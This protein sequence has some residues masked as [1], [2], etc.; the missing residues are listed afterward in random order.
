MTFE[1]G[2]LVRPARAHLDD[3]GDPDP[4]GV[5]VGWIELRSTTTPRL[6]VRWIWRLDGTRAPAARPGEFSL[7]PSDLVAFT[8]LEIL[9]RLDLQAARAQAK[10]VLAR[11]ERSRAIPPA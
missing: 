1:C 9:S 11:R 5:A 2:D 8:A 6:F 10:A 4:K 3:D 7:A